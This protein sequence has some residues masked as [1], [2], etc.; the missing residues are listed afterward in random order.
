M[1]HPAWTKRKAWRPFLNGEMNLWSGS[2]VDESRA[3]ASVS[4]ANPQGP[5]TARFHDVRLSDFAE[6]A[7]YEASTYPG[8][9]LPRD[10]QQQA[11]NVDSPAR[12]STSAATHTE[13]VDAGLASG[14]IGKK[15]GRDG[16]PVVSPVHVWGVREDWG[17]RSGKW[18]QG[19]KA[20]KEEGTEDPQQDG[21][22][23]KTRRRRPAA[24]G[25]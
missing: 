2:P 5:N 7:S 3:A 18:G 24:D 22:E 16:P 21:S 6:E 12:A 9:H 25:A 23:R 15:K 20:F 14:P 17:P 10:A 4:H 11:A 13:P 8:R 1:S 19:T